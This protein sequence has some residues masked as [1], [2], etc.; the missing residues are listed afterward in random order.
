MGWHQWQM[1]R[2][3]LEIES[4]FVHHSL[5]LIPLVHQEKFK[6]TLKHAWFDVS[7]A[8]AGAKLGFNGVELSFVLIGGFKLD[9]FVPFVVLALPDPS[10]ESFSVPLLGSGWFQLKCIESLNIGV[11]NIWLVFAR[12]LIGFSK[13]DVVVGEDKFV[14]FADILHEEM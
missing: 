12:H 3:V 13:R 8:K 2:S 11:H 10:D 6:Y 9:V 7:H 4:D 14:L 5:H 1:I